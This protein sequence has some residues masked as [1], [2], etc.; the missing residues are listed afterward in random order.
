[1]GKG[2][3]A[4]GG[5]GAGVAGIYCLKE[6]TIGGGSDLD[7]KEFMYKDPAKGNE[8]HT[9]FVWFLFGIAICVVCIIVVNA[10]ANKG[11][12]GYGIVRG[13]INFGLVGASTVGLFISADIIGKMAK[14]DQ[15]AGKE[16]FILLSVCASYV[17]L[18]MFFQKSWN[19]NVKENW[20]W[21]LAQV[22]CVLTCVGCAASVWGHWWQHGASDASMYSLI[23]LF[24]ALI[25]LREISQHIKGEKCW[26]RSFINCFKRK[27]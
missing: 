1:M 27:N 19:G 24:I 8:M 10:R 13:V 9:P 11:R 25:L 16:S 17:L 22:V 20:P 5:I 15:T 7:F 3:G 6:M 12:A 26:I 21:K 23:G 18:Y 4:V 2:L 14:S